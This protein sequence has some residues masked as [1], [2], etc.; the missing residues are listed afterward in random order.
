MRP[1]ER[2]ASELETVG[3]SHRP[4]WARDGPTG[5]SLSHSAGFSMQH[6]LLGTDGV[7]PCAPTPG[8][9]PPA[10]QLCGGAGGDPGEA[11]GAVVHWEEVGVPG[12]G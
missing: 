4:I 7:T 11:V 5:W 1:W 8:D 2:K 3:G 12:E 6:A 9:Q 10:V